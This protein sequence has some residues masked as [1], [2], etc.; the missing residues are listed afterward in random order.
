MQREWVR[1]VLDGCSDVQRA[2]KNWMDRD[3]LFAEEVIRQCGENRYLS[4]VNDGQ[5]EIKDFVNLVSDH[6]GLEV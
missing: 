1:F 5:I 4:F 2:F 6:F 3:H